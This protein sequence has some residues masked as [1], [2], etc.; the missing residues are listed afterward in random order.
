MVREG[1]IQY[2]KDMPALRVQFMTDRS[3]AN[4]MEVI[5]KATSKPGLKLLR[6]LTIVPADNLKDAERHCA[7]VSLPSACKENLLQ[8]CVINEVCLPSLHFDSFCCWYHDTKQVLTFFVSFRR[9]QQLREQCSAWSLMT[10]LSLL[11]SARWRCGPTGK[12][13]A[14]PALV[15][16]SPSVTALTP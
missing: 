3:V 4:G 11:G 2:D 13:S 16:A 15:M 7:L 1:M 9:N 5:R 10:P 6:H 12:C 14:E 8:W